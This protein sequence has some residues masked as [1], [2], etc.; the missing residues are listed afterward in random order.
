[1]NTKKTLTQ[2]HNEL[3]T[4]TITVRTLV[5]ES[6][7]VITENEKNVHALLGMYSDALI[8]SQILKA[9]SMLQNGTSTLLTGIPIVL[10][11]N[12]LVNGEIATGASKILENYQATY[13]ATV[14]KKLKEAGAVVIGAGI[15]WPD[16]S[17]GGTKCTLDL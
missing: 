10:K 8:E 4:G 14:V 13:D 12:I 9:E 2:L 11:D 16:K 6:K 1:M 7:S 17:T 5:D 3:L 15:L